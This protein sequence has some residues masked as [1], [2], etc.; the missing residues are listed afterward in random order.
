M[1]EKH[2]L[3]FCAQVTMA[4]MVLG[5]IVLPSFQLLDCQLVVTGIVDESMR[6]FLGCL[7]DYPGSI[8]AI[9]DTYLKTTSILG[10]SC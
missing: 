9:L 10:S 2:V 1:Q 4:S 8:S 3:H 7:G 5:K 6:E